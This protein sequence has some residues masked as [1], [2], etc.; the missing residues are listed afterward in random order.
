[1]S[2]RSTFV[3]VV[4]SVAA[5]T[6]MGQSAALR[7]TATIGHS[8]LPGVSVR[9]GSPA[10]QGVRSTV[11]GPTGAYQFAA[12][13]PG[14]YIVAFELEGFEH[15]RKEIGL[16][17]SQTSIVDVDLERAHFSEEV[18]VSGA[19]HYFAS[20]RSGMATS[21]AAGE[22][23]RLPVE[24]DVL[25][26]ASLAAGVTQTSLG[27]N[28]QPVISGSPGYDNLIMVNGAVITNSD[29]SLHSLFIEDAIEQTTVLSGAISAEYGRF[30]GGV[31]NA[32]TKSG[33]NQFSGSFRDSVSNPK[34]TEA[35]PYFTAPETPDVIEHIFQETLGGFAVRDYLWFF[36]AAR[37]AKSSRGRLTLAAN[38]PYVSTTE[39]TRYELKTTS[40]VGTSHTFSLS[41]MHVDNRSS[42]LT[43]Q[44]I[45]DRDSLFNGVF[46]ASMA[47]IH[48][49]G[50]LQPNLL[51]EFQYSR[52]RFANKD[53]GSPF[54]DL[55]RGTPIVDKGSGTRF[56]S[57]TFCG[58]CGARRTYNTA[59][60]VKGSRF[61]SSERTGDHT[62]VVGSEYFAEQR[63]VNNYLSGSGFTVLVPAVQIQDFTVYPRLTA[64]TTTIR[65]TPVLRESNGNDLAT[66]SSFI[67]DEWRFNDR[68]SGNVG[69]RYDR[70]HAVDADRTPVSNDDALSPRLA[71]VYDVSGSGRHYL[72]AG[73]SRYVSDVTDGKIAGAGE[74]AGVASQIDFLYRGPNVNAIGTP[75]S[76]LVLPGDALRILFDW[77]NR[78]CDASGHCG[79]ANM[80][81]LRPGGLRDTPSF[82]ARVG[83]RLASPR[84]DEVFVGYALT[85]VPELSAKVNAVLRRWSRFYNYRVDATTPRARDTF[86]IDH[87]IAIVENTNDI[88]RTYQAV[89]IQSQWQRSRFRAALTYTWSTLRGN[90]EQENGEVRAVPNAALRSYY[91]EFL[92]YTQRLPIGYLSQ[93]QRHR[94]RAWLGY[95]VPV[96]KHIG[97]VNVS[98]LQSFD[99]GRPYSARALIRTAGYEG[100]APNVTYSGGIR[101]DVYYFSRRSAFRLDNVV[102]TDV[103]L[104]FRHP[105]RNGE[106]FV[107]AYLLNA[108][109]QSVPL[110][111]DT[112]VYTAATS[113]GLKTFN[114]FTQ[115]PAEGVHYVLGP[116]FGHAIGPDSY[117]RP[118]TWQFSLGAH[119]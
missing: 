15:V 58:V 71:A 4:L 77:F 104:N 87:D 79:T 64:G 56:N 37:Q 118:R 62:I 51:V 115:V 55:I 84:V 21:F 112:T 29:G 99:S 25:S 34:W 45:Y 40:R 72:S 2:S 52:K 101:D 5:G 48:Y 54:T 23:V 10:L 61:V 75:P 91:P 39:E 106:I 8:P 46:P 35:T 92:S 14:T 97:N 98:I 31:I 78:A 107:Q 43:F 82:A 76:Q 3:A 27:I 22:M 103:A 83:D 63:T 26:T 9:I 68:L 116:S 41:G 109:N 24:R 60:A 73:Y 11:T 86:G 38:A 57:A 90:D 102:Q 65:W 80:S 17:L 105:I 95:D 119:F 42:N 94:A 100:A 81:L 96:N 74:V 49:D 36:A 12:L 59:Y 53:N 85:P 111:V 50:L 30:T 16:S 13:P 7:G 88:K 93:D 66:V 19:G 114:P 47:A 69:F 1:M 117:Q 108:F 113:D 18:T 110:S 32:I 44:K 20:D 33:G 28:K 6:A 89:Q 70:N 67:N